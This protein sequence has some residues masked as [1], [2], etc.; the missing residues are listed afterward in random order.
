MIGN[1]LINKGIAKLFCDWRSDLVIMVFII[2]FS[3]ERKKYTPRS[4]LVIIVAGLKTVATGD[5]FI[6]YN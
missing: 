4:R 1:L 6:D 2:V 5:L 3:S